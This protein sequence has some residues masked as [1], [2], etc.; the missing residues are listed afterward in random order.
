MHGVDQKNKQ[1]RRVCRDEGDKI[2]G[3]ISNAFD[4][5][6]SCVGPAGTVFEP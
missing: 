1:G 2:Q 6:S 4:P 5:R 3:F